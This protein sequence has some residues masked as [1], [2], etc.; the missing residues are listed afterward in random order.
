VGPLEIVAVKVTP[1]PYVVEGLEVVTASVGTDAFNSRTMV[2]VV[3]PVLAVN[4]T[5]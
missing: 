4:V 2:W 3:L 5:D 1:P